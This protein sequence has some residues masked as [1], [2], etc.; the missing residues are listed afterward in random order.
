M[1]ETPSATVGDYLGLIKR[2]SV[3]CNFV[4][5][6]IRRMQLKET[7]FGRCGRGLPVISTCTA[8]FLVL[9]STSTW[10][11]GISTDFLAPSL[12]VM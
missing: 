11:R 1:T 10:T 7:C 8:A 3:V 6:T 4:H 12:S 5:T 9:L 2:K